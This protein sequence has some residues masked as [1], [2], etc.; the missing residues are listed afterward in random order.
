MRPDG[1][2][3]VRQYWRGNDRHNWAL[4]EVL[5]GKARRVGTVRSE[6]EYRAFLGDARTGS[7]IDYQMQRL[8]LAEDAKVKLTSSDG[9]THWLNVTPAEVEAIHRVLTEPQG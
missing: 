8:G 2:R 4:Y 1:Y 5:G 6:R 3:Y 9:E 7:Y